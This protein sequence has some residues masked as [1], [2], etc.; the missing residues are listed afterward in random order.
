MRI[1]W[2]GSRLQGTP[3]WRV[4]EFTAKTCIGGLSNEAVE[5]AKDAAEKE[6]QAARRRE[7]EEEEEEEEEGSGPLVLVALI[8]FHSSPA[9]DPAV[10]AGD[11]V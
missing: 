1:F 7:E 6:S 10:A 5:E 9:V 11:D 4:Q 8:L 2:S 3:N